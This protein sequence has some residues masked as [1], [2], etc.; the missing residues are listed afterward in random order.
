MCD[1]E[2][3]KPWGFFE[4]IFCEEFSGRTYFLYSNW[5][6]SLRFIITWEYLRFIIIWGQTDSE[7]KKWPWRFMSACKLWWLSTYSSSF[8]TSTCRKLLEISYLSS[9]YEMHSVI[10]YWWHTTKMFKYEKEISTCGLR[11]RMVFNVKFF[12]D[13]HIFQTSISTFKDP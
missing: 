10:A 13:Q 11:T 1:Y 7:R 12:Q 8:S 9:D 5:P 2:Q 4:R 3:T 6:Q